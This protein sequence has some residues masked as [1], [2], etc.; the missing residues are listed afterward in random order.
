MKMVTLLISNDTYAEFLK[1]RG[2]KTNDE[3]LIELLK[4][5]NV[6]Q[7]KEDIVEVEFEEVGNDEEDVVFKPTPTQTS[8]R[9]TKTKTNK[10]TNNVTIEGK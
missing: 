5:N 4:S 6:S 1:V 2:H 9:N 7:N 10:K 3:C 8:K